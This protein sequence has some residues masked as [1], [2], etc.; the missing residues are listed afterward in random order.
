MGRRAFDDC[1]DLDIMVGI[2][3]PHR[4]ARGARASRLPVAGWH[5]HQDRWGHYRGLGAWPLVRAGR[6]PLA[7]I[8]DFAIVSFA[9]PLNSEEVI[10]E[11]RDL[12]GVLQSASPRQPM[13]R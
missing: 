3:R 6:Y 13:P 2:A 1:S 7:F 8:S 5:D 12:D 10:A 11:S 9:S 4:G